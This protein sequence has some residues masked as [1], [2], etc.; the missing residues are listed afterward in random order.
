MIKKR[1]QIVE[2]NSVDEARRLCPW[3]DMFQRVDN[4]KDIV[5]WY[6][7]TFIE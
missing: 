6:C 5:K 1:T 3:A 4:D 7:S 2:A